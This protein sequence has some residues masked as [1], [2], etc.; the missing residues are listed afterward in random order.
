MHFQL[1]KACTPLFCSSFLGA[2]DPTPRI[3]FDI[4][5]I[6]HPHDSI[7]YNPCT[8]FLDQL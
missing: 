2:K 8:A 6:I 5:R 7:F 3:N 1:D 4:T